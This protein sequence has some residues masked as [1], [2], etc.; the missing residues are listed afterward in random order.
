VLNPRQILDELTYSW[1][2]LTQPR[3]FPDLEAPPGGW[4]VILGLSFPKSGTNLL[5]QVL[6]AF[7][8]VGPF[9]DRSFDVF[10]TF[11][12]AS[13][14]RAGPVE[15]LGFLRSL[16]PGD[17]ASA[18][19]FAWPEVVAEVCSPRYVPFFISRDPRDVVVSHVFYV[20][21]KAKAHVHHA[22]YSQVLTNFDDRLKTS[23]LGLPKAEVEFPDIGQ[24]FEPYLG[25][26][27]REEVL[28][29]RF[30]DFI[31]QRRSTL[32]CVVDHFLPRVGPLKMSRTE[33]LSELEQN[34]VPERSRTFRSGKTGEWRKYFN[35]EHKRLFKE[36]AG[37][38]LIRLGYEQDYEW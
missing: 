2:R 28:A 4:P 8:R 11:A 12:A 10:A 34:I 7:T 29:L 9:T 5:I 25:W 32:V 36:V 15:A 3:R 21:E 38:L 16:R 33:I 19:F 23:I 1:Q 26:I 18:H 22:Y 37:E 13:G 17:I 6:S 20:T 14:Q 35:E 30:E 24:R 31:H 27:G